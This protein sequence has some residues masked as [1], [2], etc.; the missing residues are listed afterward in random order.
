MDYKSY[1]EKGLHIGSGAIEAAHRNVI[2]K[3]MKQSGQRWTPKLAQNVLNLRTCY[4]SEH[5]DELV[6]FIKKTAA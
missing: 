6:E 4:M 1:E 3:R 2:Q 5:W